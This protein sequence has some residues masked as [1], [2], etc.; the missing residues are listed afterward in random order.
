M[1]KSKIIVPALAMIA[2]STAASIAGSVAW[3]TAS[4]TVTINAGNYAVVK[5][6]SDL[7]YA[8]SNGVGTTANAASSMVSFSG[9]LTDGS[10][11]H[12]SETVF[13]P[14]SDGKDIAFGTSLSAEDFA[15]K[16]VRKT[17]SDSTVVYTAATFDIS[18]TLD[19]APSDPDKALYLDCSA[20]KSRFTTTGEVATAAGFRMAFI[21]K[22][23][24]PSGSSQYKKVFADLQ[25]EAN[26]K[27]VKDTENYEG[28]EYAAGVVIDSTFSSALPSASE[29]GQTIAKMTT[30]RVD[31][32]GVFH[33]TNVSGSSLVVTLAYTVV[34]W[35][36]GNDP[37]IHKRPNASEYQEVATQ[38]CFEAVDL[39]AA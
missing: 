32:L 26:C 25:T 11:N 7:T 16:M 37:E 15:S 29:E 36:D 18:F 20:G 9:K 24:T 33:N 28:E 6:N 14:T 3:F 12:L 13:T 35:F 34:C 31:C 38:L 1:K 4:R 17:L 5:I 21:P 10:F 2:F 30:Q 22:G 39:P 23:S 8:M 19:F 27:Y